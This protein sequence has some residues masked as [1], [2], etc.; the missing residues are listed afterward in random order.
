MESKQAMRE[1]A[2]KTLEKAKLLDQAKIKAG[3]HKWVTIE[4]CRI[5]KKKTV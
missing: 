5:L 1:Q 3:T 2:L 4:D